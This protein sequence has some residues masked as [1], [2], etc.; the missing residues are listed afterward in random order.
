[1][2]NSVI[3]FGS[4]GQLGQQLTQDLS[5]SFDIHPFSKDECSITDYENVANK[6]RIKV[7]K[8][9]SALR[10]QNQTN[11]IESTKIKDTLD[12]I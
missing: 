10:N 1:M 2:E 9:R 3:V 12:I 7:R 11:S 5:S 6:Q 4:K 8:K